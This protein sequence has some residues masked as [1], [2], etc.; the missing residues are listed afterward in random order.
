MTTVTEE[1]K[2]FWNNFINKNPN[3]DY[4]KKQTIDAW[5]FGNTP[6]MADDLLALV[7]AGKKVATCCLLRAYRDKPVQSHVV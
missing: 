4:L 3:L 7:L 6:E 5:S 2:V 1:V